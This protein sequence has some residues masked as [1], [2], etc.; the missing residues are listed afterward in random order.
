MCSADLG[1]EWLPK[2]ASVVSGI[3][4][5]DS[6]DSK[7]NPPW[8]AGRSRKILILSHNFRQGRWGG[9]KVDSPVKK[10]DAR[11]LARSAPPHTDRAREEPWEGD[12]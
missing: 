12:G 2:V 9:F 6:L 4:Q 10:P 1:R 7:R 8:P 11:K 5:L 3:H